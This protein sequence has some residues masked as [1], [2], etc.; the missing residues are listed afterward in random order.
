VRKGFSSKT[1]FHKSQDL[2]HVPVYIPASSEI[3]DITTYLWVCICTE[4]YSERTAPH[5]K[6]AEK[7]DD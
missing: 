2:C 5:V 4:Q 3:F 6:Y 1:E 7:T